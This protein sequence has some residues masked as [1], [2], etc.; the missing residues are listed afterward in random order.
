MAGEEPYTLLELLNKANEDY[1]DGFLAMYYN[2]K[3][4]VFNED[5]SGD[6]LARF[7]VLEL[8]ETFEPE[9]TRAQQ[10]AVARHVLN[11]GMETLQHIIDVL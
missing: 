1:P 10:I 5:G 8:T 11:R 2:L 3:T 6:S 4:G 9:A 7:I